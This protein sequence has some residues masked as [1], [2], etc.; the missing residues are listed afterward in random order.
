MKYN[1]IN[2]KQYL[3]LLFSI[4]K[5]N[6]AKI[7]SITSGSD[8]NLLK[9]DISKLTKPI[10]EGIKE[11]NYKKIYELYSDEYKKKNSLEYYT[12]F[13]K[14]VSPKEKFV[15]SEL[16]EEY[17]FIST[18]GIGLVLYYKLHYDNK[19]KVILGL[20]FKLQNDNYVLENLNFNYSMKI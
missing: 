4:K 20:K 17:L 11:K 6:Q 9:A 2:P 16:Y 18:E 12:E 5:S 13:S 1:I 8:N 19:K 14:K 7:L 3:I 10:L 15:N